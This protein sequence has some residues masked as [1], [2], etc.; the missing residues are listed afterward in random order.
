MWILND[1]TFKQYWYLCDINESS[2]F[3]DQC[4]YPAPLVYV[5]LLVVGIITSHQAEDRR[6][7]SL[8]HLVPVPPVNPLQIHRPNHRLLALATTVCP[9]S[10]L[11]TIKPS[12]NNSQSQ[13]NQTHHT[14]PNRVTSTSSAARVPVRNSWPSFAY[15]ASLVNRRKALCEQRWEDCCWLVVTGA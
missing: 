8:Y 13:V 10:P 6:K 11:L 1:F 12:H 7:R 15:K 5:F 2:W 9:E 4:W 14:T 3:G